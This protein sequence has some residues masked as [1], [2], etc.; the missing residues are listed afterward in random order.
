MNAPVLNLIIDS[1]EIFR[2]I[3]P[4]PTPLRVWGKD[5]IQRVFLFVRVHAGDYTGTGFG[6]TRG[7]DL[8]SAIERQIKPL[9]LRQPVSAIRQIWNTARQGARMTGDTGIF[10]RALSLVD[11]ALWDL[12]GHVLGV[13]LWRMWGGAQQR[14][15]CVAICGYYRRE[16]SVAAL[17]QEAERLLAAGYTR[18]KIPFGEDAVL[19]VQRVRTLREVSGPHAMIGLDASGIFNSCKDAVQAWRTVEA[20]DI[21]FLEDPFSAAQWELV[22]QLA[23]STPVKIAFG[24][25]ITSPLIIQRLSSD[26]RI[27]I[28]RPDATVLHGIS[29]FLQAVA[30][31]VENGLAVFP[32][33]YP[34]LHAPLAGALGLS[35]IEESPA[36]ADTVGFGILRAQQPD[37]HDGH[38]HLTDRPGLGIVWDEEVLGMKG[39]KEVNG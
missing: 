35:M 29:G 33:Y 19:D 28:V 12:L 36:E 16:D 25:S 34:D 30:P 27:D 39:V 38:W 1:L 23:N 31:A 3:V 14:V 18:F 4:L 15:P 21:A 20:F 7:M 24:E 17:R 10:A 6:L 2:V 22:P 13:P 8:G 11:T 9:V 32:H 37:I 5:I 26:M